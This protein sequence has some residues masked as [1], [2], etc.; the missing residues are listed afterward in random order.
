[1]K[2]FLF[3]FLISSA[4]G[5]YISCDFKDYTWS[6]IGKVSTCIVTS[7][8]FSDNSTHITGVD[9]TN[10]RGKL[11]ADVKVIQFGLSYKCP[12]N[13][14]KIPKGFLKHFPNLIGFYFYE[15]ISTLN[16]D[17][18]DEYPN[19]QFY[20]HSLSNLTRIPGNFFKSTPNMKVISFAFN[21][22]QN[23]GANLLD[24]LKSLQQVYFTGNSC[25]NKKAQNA[26]QVPALIEELKQKCPDI[27]P[28]QIIPF[29]TQA[30]LWLLS[31]FNI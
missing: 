27:E 6:V 28:E 26:S 13:L 31:I 2:I 17:E 21:E 7:A 8:D 23:V 9:G 12:E 14:H 4:S 5:V 15:C 19:L 16:G 29:T 20:Y 22:I 30:L 18:L 11:N 10:L 25:I 24:H 1:M 3:L